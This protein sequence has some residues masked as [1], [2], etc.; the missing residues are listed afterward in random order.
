MYY[1]IAMLKKNPDFKGKN[2]KGRNDRFLFDAE[3]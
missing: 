2:F 1:N 3:S